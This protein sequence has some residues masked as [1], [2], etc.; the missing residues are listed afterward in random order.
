MT[1][2][3][4][5]APEGFTVSVV[6]GDGFDTVQVQE[7]SDRELSSLCR[8]MGRVTEVFPFNHEICV[9]VKQGDTAYFARFRADQREKRP[10]Y[11]ATTGEPK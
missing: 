6:R 8:F 1:S 2:V 9:W 7:N 5:T 4:I 3:Q 10:A 11:I